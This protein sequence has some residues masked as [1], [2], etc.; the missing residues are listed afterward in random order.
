MIWRE[1]DRRGK[2]L[3]H[4]A[5]AESLLTILV[6]YQCW[7][8]FFLQLI[9]AIRYFSKDMNLDRELSLAELSLALITGLQHK[10]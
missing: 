9:A 6:S 2:P 7:G 1:K 5:R 10:C 4:P 8:S 3:G